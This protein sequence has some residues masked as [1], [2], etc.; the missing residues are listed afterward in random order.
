MLTGYIGQSA[1]VLTFTTKSGDKFRKK[2]KSES[3]LNRA[4]AGWTAKGGFVKWTPTLPSQMMRSRGKK[5][6]TYNLG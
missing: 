5:R 1:W 3:S 2:F 4:M 6:A